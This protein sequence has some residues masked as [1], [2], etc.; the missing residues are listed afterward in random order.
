MG[1]IEQLR[2]EHEQFRR[3]L[4][5]WD[6]LLVE[7]ES[8]V[9]TFA[10]LRVKEEALWVRDEVLLHIEREEAIV[11]PE[12][13]NRD[14]E[15]AK[16]LQNFRDDHIRLHQLADQL[17]E[18][19]WK[20]QLGTATNEQVQ[21]VFKTLR[22]QLLDHLAREDGGLPPLLMHLLSSEEDERL[23]LE[24]QSYRPE[25]AAPKRS[26]T[27]LNG[28]IH[29]WL[30]DLLL[31]HLEALTDLNLAEARAIWQ[32][33]ADALLNHSEAEDEIALPVYEQLGNFP[34]GGQPSLFFAEHKGIERMLNSLTQRLENLS[35]ND[36]FL[37]RKVVIGLDKYM[38]FRHLIEHHTLREQN[39][40]YPILDE[41]AIRDE[42]ER[43]ANTLKAAWEKA[44]RTGSKT[45]RSDR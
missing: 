19:A 42:K 14:Q 24:W 1:L 5:N 22:W 25:E 16:R 36:P 27:E 18:L 37:R 2:L 44:E 30:D 15:L 39:I 4:A 38:L 17:S 7:L 32:K 3:R 10:A 29:A 8:G 33:F 28:S 21:R 34:E 43:I 6:D 12:I 41:K 9:G 40:F 35:P 13:Q 23:S 11:F 26:L 31:R 45:K 20:R